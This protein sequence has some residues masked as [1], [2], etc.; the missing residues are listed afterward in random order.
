MICYPMRRRF[1]G[2]KLSS[3]LCNSR[4]QKRAMK[5]N[6]RNS[7]EVQI[8]VSAQRCCNVKTYWNAM[9]VSVKSRWLT[10]EGIRWCKAAAWPLFQP[11]FPS[12]F[13]WGWIV[14]WISSNICVHIKPIWPDSILPWAKRVKSI[15]LTRLQHSTAGYLSVDGAE[16]TVLDIHLSIL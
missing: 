8:S 15:A 9:W 16:S 13:R 7:R 14:R 5:N 6:N 11:I 10:A 2:F 12:F 4:P 1:Q 3:R